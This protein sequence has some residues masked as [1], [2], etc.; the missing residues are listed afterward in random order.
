VIR[1]IVRPNSLFNL[2]N[3]PR[4]NYLGDDD[5]EYLDWFKTDILSSHDT[6]ITLYHGN[7]NTQSSEEYRKVATSVTRVLGV[8]ML[9]NWLG[10]SKANE[11]IETSYKYFTDLLN[12]RG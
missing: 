2:W 9:F 1:T 10:D 6:E 7:I 11:S 5:L 12:T 4:T 3:V 8:N